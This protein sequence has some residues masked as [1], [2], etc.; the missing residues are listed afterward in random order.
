MRP[1]SLFALPL[2]TL[3]LACAAPTP[4][5]GTAD[6]ERI[7][8]GSGITTWGFWKRPHRKFSVVYMEQP[9]RPGERVS[10]QIR[11]GRIEP[12]TAILGAGGTITL[13][14]SSS[15]KHTVAIPFDDLIRQIAPGAGFEIRVTRPGARSIFLIDVPG[16]AEATVFVSPGPYSVVGSD[17][18]FELE[19][20]DPGRQKLY[21]WRTDEP[22]IFSWVKI[23]HDRVQRFDFN[24][25]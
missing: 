18:R 6:P 15:R 23:A 24:L 14:N 1:R 22:D 2:V 9:A 20:V 21:G 16:E 10:L 13:H 11:A 12:A 4:Q 3:A 25:R 19:D 5:I 17:G 7:T 8:R